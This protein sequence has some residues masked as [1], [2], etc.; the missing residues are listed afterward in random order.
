[1]HPSSSLPPG[2]RSSLARNTSNMDLGIKIHEYLLR[3]IHGIGI[4]IR[5]VSI[6]SLNPFLFWWI[7]RIWLLSI[8]CPYFDEACVVYSMQPVSI[9]AKLN[10]YL[11]SMCGWTWTVT[12]ITVEGKIY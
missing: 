2:S 10:L 1:V 12:L 3:H 6:T 7:I 9:G 5:P 8:T 4:S 11:A